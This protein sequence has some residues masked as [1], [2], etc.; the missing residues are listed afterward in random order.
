MI[1]KY[2]ENET[3]ENLNICDEVID[4]ATFVDCRFVNCSFDRCELSFCKVGECDFVKCRFSEIKSDSSEIKFLTFSD[5]RIFGVNW[6]MFSSTSRF[7]EPIAKISS[8]S[9]KYNFFTQMNF[10]KFAFKDS[11]I[12]SSTF[13]ECNLAESNFNGCDLK[14]TEFI[15]CDISKADFRNATGY[16]VD[17]TT[18]KLSGARFSYPEVENLLYSLDIKIE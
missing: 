14:D 4:G 1:K 13:A 3:F 10:K 5:C 2:F 11:S 7:N 8:C 6:A 18:C 16:K 17:V 15:K 9:L 12:S